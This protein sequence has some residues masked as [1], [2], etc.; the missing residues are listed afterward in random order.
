MNVISMN[1]YGEGIEEL[2]G[3]EEKKIGALP[4]TATR[5]GNKVSVGY[6]ARA[7]AATFRKFLSK[8]EIDSVPNTRRTKRLQT[9]PTKRLHDVL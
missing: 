9:M 4:R 7:A 1:F 6:I 3:V 5:G 2:A 8:R